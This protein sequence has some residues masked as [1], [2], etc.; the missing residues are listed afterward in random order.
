MLSLVCKIRSTK[1]RMNYLRGLSALAA[2]AAAVTVA[3]G[4]APGPQT[5]R[6]APQ[7]PARDTPAQQEKLAPA[8]GMI[9][10][11]VIAADT[12]R[13]VKRARVSVSANELPGGRGVLTDDNGAFQILELPAGRYTV[14][15]S[16]SGFVSLA[17]GQRRPLQAGTPVQLAEGQEIRNV[18][19][20]LPRGSVIT[21]HVYDETGDPLPGVVVRV[22]RY[23]FQQGNRRLSTAGT[24]QTDDLGQFRVWG[25]MP[26]DY[27]VDAQSRIN[28]PFG[29][30]V[31]RGRGG[32][33]AGAIAGFVGAIAGPNVGNLFNPEDESQKAYAPTYFPGVAAVEEAQAVTVGLG[34]TASGIDFALQLVRV[35]RISGRVLNPDGSV[36][37]RGN[38]NLTTE[39]QVPGSGNQ[40]GAN[41][42]SRL[43]GDGTFSIANVPPGRYI[44]RARGNNAEWPQYANL[45]VTV[46]GIDISDISVTVTEGAT[47]I[48]TVSF[49]SGRTA[50]PDMGQVRISSV[51]IEP[52]LTNSQARIEEDNSFKI[53]AI[54]V[55]AHLFR[56]NGQLRGWSLKS[57]TLDGRDITDTPIDVRAGQEITRVAVT[58]TDAVNEINGTITGDQGSPLTEYTV[59][60]FSTD[61]AFW[62]PLSRHIATARPDQ[63]GSFRIRGLPSGGYYLVAVDPAQ[64]G[65][66]YDAS[67]LE[68]HRFGAAQVTLGEGE[69]KTQDFRVRAP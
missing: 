56:P 33:A 11:R 6:P 65:E 5:Q 37:T 48:G 41:Y 23:Q 8:A 62:R 30:P 16:K 68:K 36:T 19:V 10:G 28:L 69:T 57:V 34:Q 9:A 42:G 29:G 61:S 60:A 38:V 50:P 31:A 67:Y 59:L 45:P 2:V 4:Q 43:S 12:G 32:P 35:A 1:V 21:G 13:P 20:R 44:L 51:A 18:D 7:Q 46:G 27:Y 64:Q 47:V 63:T 53:V 40:L 58:F 14:S 17:Y 15:V 55:G 26:G 52:G 22:L 54:P 49:P 24:A 66:W 25:L 39:T 3:S